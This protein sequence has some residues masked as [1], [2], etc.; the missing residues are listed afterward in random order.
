[1]VDFFVFDTQQLLFL[2]LVINL[3]FESDEQSLF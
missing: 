3:Q 1:M 2:L